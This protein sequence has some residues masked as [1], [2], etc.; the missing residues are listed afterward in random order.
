MKTVLSIKTAHIPED[1]KITLK[2]GPVVAKGSGGTLGKDSNPINVELNLLRKTKKKFQVTKGGEIERYWLVC[3]NCSHVQ[4]MSAAVC[5]C[6]LC[7]RC[8]SSKIGLLM[9]LK[10]SLAKSNTSTGLG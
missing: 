7:Y 3:I 2:G 6:P 5:V 1:I 4:N 8:H 9:K 10:I